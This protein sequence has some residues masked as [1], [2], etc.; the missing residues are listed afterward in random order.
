MKKPVECSEFDC[1]KDAVRGFTPFINNGNFDNPVQTDK[2]ESVYWCEGHE[3][4]LRAKF[5]GQSGI[6][7]K[8]IHLRSL[9]M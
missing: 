2:G 9:N 6:W 3:N 1:T 5:I 7:L 8:E 4:D